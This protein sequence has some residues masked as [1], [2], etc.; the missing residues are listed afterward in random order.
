MRRSIL[1]LLSLL[2]AL[3][4][5]SCGDGPVTQQSYI[6]QSGTYSD[7]VYASADGPILVEIRGEPF[8]GA[9]AALEGTVLAALDGAFPERPA[10]FTLDPSQAAHANYRIAMMFDPPKTASGLQLC[11]GEGLVQQPNEPGKV[12][13]LMSFCHKGE[14]LAESWGW[15]RKVTGPE[16]ARLAKLVHFA[17]RHL[18]QA[19][20]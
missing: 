9:Q 4:L 2:S 3:G 7:F 19:P 6:R 16:D 20:K 15:V 17:A 5:S 13:I 12:N 11:A 14:R 1:G 10:R 8:Q 18:V